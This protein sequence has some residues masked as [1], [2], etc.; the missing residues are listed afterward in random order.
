M[1]LPTFPLI[2]MQLE[3]QRKDYC[4]GQKKWLRIYVYT[5]M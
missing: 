5:E 2:Q 1:V 3:M 4:Y